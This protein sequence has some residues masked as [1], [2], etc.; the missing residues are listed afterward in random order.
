M[1]DDLTS[2]DIDRLLKLEAHVRLMF[3]VA[4][5]E[6][7]FLGMGRAHGLCRSDQE[8]PLTK[9]LRRLVGK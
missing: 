7:L 3:E 5:A 1:N 4:E 2:E 8:G 9:E 6:G